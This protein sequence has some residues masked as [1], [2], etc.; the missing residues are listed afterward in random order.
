[1]LRGST[2]LIRLMV[3]ARPQDFERS[4]LRPLMAEALSPTVPRHTAKL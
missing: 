2:T 4:F 3:T 1:M